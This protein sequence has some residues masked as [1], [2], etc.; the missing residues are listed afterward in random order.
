VSNNIGR[1]LE[2]HCYTSNPLPI[3]L[4]TNVSLHLH[5]TVIPLTPY[6]YGEGKHLCLIIYN[7]IGRELR[8]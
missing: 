5:D 6:L 3:L 2:V 4:D 8:V 1:G 7:N